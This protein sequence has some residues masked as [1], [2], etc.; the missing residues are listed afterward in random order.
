LIE[1][2]AG[3]VKPFILLTRAI[4]RSRSIAVAVVLITLIVVVTSMPITRSV[5]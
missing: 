1:L 2:I 4:T 5:V 3:V